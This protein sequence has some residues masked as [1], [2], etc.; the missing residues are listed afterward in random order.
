MAAL[1]ALAG[2]HGAADLLHAHGQQA[3]PHLYR[4][5]RPEGQPAA[6]PGRRDGQGRAALGL[7][8]ARALGGAGPLRHLRRHAATAPDGQA[9]GGAAAGRPQAAGRG[10]LQGHSGDGRAGRAGIPE[11]VRALIQGFTIQ[12]CPAT[13]APRAAPPPGFERV[14]PTLVLPT[15]EGAARIAMEKVLALSP[16]PNTR[17]PE[18]AS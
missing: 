13:F 6:V 7:V 15:V 18:A 2:H 10:L 14:R 5:P 1:S 3:R 9:R 17:V 4:S 12:S 8:V 16:G 11:P